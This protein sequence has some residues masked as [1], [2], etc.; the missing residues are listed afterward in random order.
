MR[1]AADRD[2]LR[3]RR[4][5]WYGHV[6]RENGEVLATITGWTVDGRRPRGRLRSTGMDNARGDRGTS[7]LGTRLHGNGRDGERHCPSKPGNNLR[8]MGKWRA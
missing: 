1:V 5:G 8:K 3:T 4:L 7:T 2:V 6:R